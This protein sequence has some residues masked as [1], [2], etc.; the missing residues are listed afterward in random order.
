[1]SMIMLVSAATEQPCAGDIDNKTE[2]RNRNG[3]GKMYWYRLE[4]S[5]Y[6]FVADEDCN[7]RQDDGAGKSG[8]VTQL[9]GAKRETR[10]IGMFPGIGV[11]QRGQ[12][13]RARMGA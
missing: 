1:M 5:D 4:E 7:H 2:A 11:G 10:I 13:Q 3:L 8:K 9:T 6:R 12:Q